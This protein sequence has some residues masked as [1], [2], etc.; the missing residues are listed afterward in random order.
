MH[1]KIVIVFWRNK[2][3][4]LQLVQKIYQWAT[5]SFELAL[6]QNECSEDAFAELTQSNLHKVLIPKNLGFGGGINLGLQLQTNKPSDY[7]LLLNTDAFIKEA[8]LNKLLQFFKKEASTF[9]VA[10]KLIEG[11]ETN[12][13]TYVGGC[14]IAKNVNTRILESSAATN[15]KHIEVDYNIGAVILINNQLL[16]EVGYLDEAYFFSGEIADWCYC[17]QQKG[18]KNVC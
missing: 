9:S 8:E 18:F 6:V 7:T 3:Q 11:N 1:I 10:P 4:T 15:K 5:I 17:A 13:K 14:N 2:A 16:K 12:S